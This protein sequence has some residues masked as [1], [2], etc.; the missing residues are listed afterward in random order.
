MPKINLAICALYK[1]RTQLGPHP[2]SSTQPLADNK[3]NIATNPS[4]GWSVFDN[5]PRGGK[6]HFFAIAALNLNECAAFLIQSSPPFKSL[7]T[8]RIRVLR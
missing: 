1:P 4:A 8:S 5:L 3:K 6:I 7:F 2:H